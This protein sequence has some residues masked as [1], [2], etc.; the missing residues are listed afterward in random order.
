MNT[1]YKFKK[2]SYL[3]GNA[4][5]V[6][7]QLTRIRKARGKLT[8]YD[9][10]QE[11]RRESNVL[12]AY[13]E[14]DN[15]KAAEQY[16]TQ[17]ARHLIACVVLVEHEEYEVKSPIRAFVNISE[18]ADSS[19]EPVI[20]VLSD[21]QMREAALEQLQSSLDQHKEKMEVFEELSEVVQGI[22]EVQ[23]TVRRHRQQPRQES[24]V[25]GR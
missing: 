23:E 11:A 16:R 19:Y 18:G 14:W 5:A 6:G 13:F 7:E 25:A 1:V 9:V 15:E 12:H 3:K 21:D 10:V 17:Q 4:Q 2:G 20:D 22:E 24:R 8:P